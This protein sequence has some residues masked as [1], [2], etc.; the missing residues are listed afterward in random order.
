MPR[1]RR[2]RSVAS[3]RQT[4]VVRGRAAAIA[5]VG[6]LVAAGCS[7]DDAGDDA[8]PPATGAP[9]S[10]STS[11]G[12]EAPGE[13]ATGPDGEIV[14]DMADLAGI[15]WRLVAYAF[16]DRPEVAVPADVDAVIRFDG[17]GRF[18][19]DGCNQQDGTAALTDG[20]VVGEIET[21]TMAACLEGPRSEVDG[22]FT[23]LLAG[24]TW[25]RSA[26]GVHAE[27]DLGWADL[28][29]REPPFPP[30][31]N[32]DDQVLLQHVG[33]DGGLQVQV[34]AGHGVG[35]AA[36]DWYLRVAWRDAPGLP[37]GVRSTEALA[38]QGAVAP[39]APASSTVVGSAIAVH[40]A[41]A[42]GVSRAAHVADDGTET[43]LDV[44]A[45]D[46]D[47]VA[48]VGLVFPQRPGVVVQWDASGAELTRSAP[49]TGR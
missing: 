1:P 5:V 25:T 47:H 15:E 14:T 8:A 9:T 10:T 28:V 24:S 6:L 31:P 21:S 42:A 40:T 43:G 45:L 11:L 22:V 29:P 13:A 33:A 32:L 16:A 30:D 46:A 23:Q 48:L 41:G 17:R 34:T 27:A 4:G 12:E 39:G 37:W 7:G 18:T 2:P 35:S 38:A 19:S 3:S 49:L 26:E 36:A 20:T 44:V